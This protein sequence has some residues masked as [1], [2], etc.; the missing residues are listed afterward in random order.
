MECDV[1]VCSVFVRIIVMTSFKKILMNFKCL[2][3]HIHYK[4]VFCSDWGTKKLRNMGDFQ[5]YH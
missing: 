4:G 2:L 3:V 5:N 1:G